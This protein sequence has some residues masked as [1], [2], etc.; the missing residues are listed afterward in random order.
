MKPYLIKEP[1]NN[2][3]YEALIV[4]NRSFGR[5]IPSDIDN[6]VKLLINLINLKIAKFLI[7]ETNK[8]IFGLGAVFIFHDVC[9]IGYLSVLSEF[10]HK[11][12]GTAIFGELINTAKKLGCKTFL[13]YASKLGE[14]IYHNFGFRSNYRTTV[15]EFP[16]KIPKM[17][18]LNEDVKIITSMPEWAAKLDRVTMGFDRC[19]FLKI[20]MSHG[21]K[22]IIDANEGYALIS[23]LRIGPIIA[24]N[25]RTAVNLI[26]R[27][28]SLGATHI[29]VPKHMKFPNKLFNLIELTERE[30]E[31]NLRMIYGKNISQKLDNFYA[32]GTYAKG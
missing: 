12:V 26:N 17:Q 3:L 18:N 32:L 29:I 24:K 11:G 13:L 7:A 9:S 31:V 28:I 22:L 6:Q 1:N 10:R 2:E 21:S 15:Y 25:L 23:G 27:G 19:E 16:S 14:P 30:N 5:L 20:K 8:K 4:L